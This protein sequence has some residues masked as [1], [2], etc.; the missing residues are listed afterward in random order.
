MIGRVNAGGGGGLQATDAIL[1][2]I[3]PAGSTVTISKGGVSKSDAGHENASDP[4]LYDY[5]FIIHQSQFDSINPWTVTATI[6]GDTMSGTVIIDAAD[7]YDLALVLYNIYRSGT[8]SVAMENVPATQYQTQLGTY[9]A[10][11]DYFNISTTGA[12]HSIARI[13]SSAIDVTNYSSLI[14]RAKYAGNAGNWKKIYVSSTKSAPDN[15][16]VASADVSGTTYA[17]YTV[18]VSSL[19][20]SYYIAVGVTNNS[21]TANTNM[22]VSDIYLK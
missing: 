17:E 20:G 2:V 1:R 3:A 7:E 12:S 4:T 19:S 14:V 18:D 9:T 10:Y 22:D 11:S 13:T 15:N 21:S 6:G 8:E 16:A 5:Y